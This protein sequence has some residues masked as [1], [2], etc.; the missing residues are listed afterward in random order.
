MRINPFGT[1]VLLAGFVSL[2]ADA[3][4]TVSVCSLTE[5]APT[6]LDVQK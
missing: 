2:L 3:A 6:K 4:L 1:L 5:M